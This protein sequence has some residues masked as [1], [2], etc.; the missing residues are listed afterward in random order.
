[1]QRTADA[2]DHSAGQSAKRHAQTQFEKWA[3][4]Y[5]RSWLNEMVFFPA[6]RICQE[7][8]L[9]WQADRADRPFRMLD[10]GCGTGTLLSLMARE[11]GAERLFGLDYAKEM[12][13][14]A[15]DKFAGSPHAEKLQMLNGDAERLPLCDGAVDIVTCCNSFHHYPHQATAVCEF[16][17]V[18]RPGGILVLIDA[19]R[20]NVIGWIVYDVGVAKIEKHVHHASWSAVRQ[21]ALGAG[22]ADVAQ[23]KSG[24][25]AP[26]LVTVARR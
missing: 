8:I 26:L 4:S 12:T 2:A 22:F 13:R 11:P 18:L 14:R 15:A 9:R 7:S 1:M 16:G 3:L 21:M 10:V 6:V 19:F 5:D 17:R 23:R 25:F 20:D 24:V